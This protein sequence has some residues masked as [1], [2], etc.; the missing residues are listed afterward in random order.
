M[1]HKGSFLYSQSS[2]LVPILSRM[3]L[4]YNFNIFFT[5][6]NLH[7]G[8]PNDIFLSVFSTENLYAFYFF[9]VHTTWPD[10]LSLSYLIVLIISGQAIFCNHLLLCF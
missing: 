6:S 4:V 5:F 10:H 7:L 1:E 8:F 9:Q 3:N 2:S